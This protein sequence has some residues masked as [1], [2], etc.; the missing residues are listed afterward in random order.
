MCSVPTTPSV[1][2]FHI[3]M[4]TVLANLNAGYVDS[5]PDEPLSLKEAMAS[6]YW[7]NSEKAIYAEFQ[8]LIENDTWEYQNAPLER[9][10]LTDCWIFKIKKD[11]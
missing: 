9:A 6:P 2:K 3:H 7:K 1:P 10:I 4:V 11:W 8:S 5:G